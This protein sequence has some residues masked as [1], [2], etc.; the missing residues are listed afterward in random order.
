MNQNYCMINIETKICDN[1]SVWDGNPETWTPPSNYLMLIQKDTPA[2]VWQLIDNQYELVVVNG[3]GGIGFAWDGTYLTTN[4]PQ[5]QFLN[6]P[7]TSG[8]VDL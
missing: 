4:E 2:K 5:P 6:Q 8:V 1:V 7:I 3:V